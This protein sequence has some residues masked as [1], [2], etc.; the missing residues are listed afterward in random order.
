MSTQEN[1]VPFMAQGV[2]TPESVEVTLQGALDL[3]GPNGENWTQGQLTRF[4]GVGRPFAYCLV[5]ALERAAP[6]Y[7]SYAAARDAVKDTLGH[8]N[9]DRW[10]NG[11][12]FGNVQLALR[13]T[14]QRLAPTP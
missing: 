1:F 10:N 11:T 3:L 8:S 12:T 6:D 7:Q 9:L 14:A 2:A 4:E 5:G 13:M